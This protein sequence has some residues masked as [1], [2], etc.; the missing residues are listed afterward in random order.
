MTTTTMMM[1]MMMIMLGL[2]KEER[3]V[4]LASPVLHHLHKHSPAI[5]KCNN[6]NDDDDDDHASA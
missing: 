6:V 2:R 1:M 5:N 3:A 4:P